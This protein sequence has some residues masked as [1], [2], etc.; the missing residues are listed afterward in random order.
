M[1][2]PSQQNRQTLLIYW[3]HLRR[4]R[5]LLSV[6]F[7]GI[8]LSTIADLIL[9]QFYKELV[10][11][12]TSVPHNQLHILLNVLILIGAIKICSTVFYRIG[13]F[14]Q[15]FF[16]ARVMSDLLNTCFRYLHGH[17][18]GFFNNAFTGSLVRKATRYSRS[19]EDIIDQVLWQIIPSSILLVSVIIILGHKSWLLGFGVLGWALVYIC[20]NVW[21][22]RYKLKF[23]VVR[24][25]SDTAVSGHL[26][27]TL[28]NHLNLKLFSGMQ[29]ETGRFEDLTDNLFTN[30][31]RVW[32]MD[33]ISQGLQ[34]LFMIVLEVGALAIA[35]H[36]WQQGNFSAGDFILLQTY[37]L[38]ISF[39]LWGVGRYLHTIYEELADAREMTEILQT[40]HE[41]RDSSDATDL[42]VTK[43]GIHFDK[44]TFSYT[45]QQTIFQDFNLTIQ[46][47][48]RVALVGSSGSGKST[49]MKLLLRFMD[50]TSGK[51]TLA[52]QEISQI[53]QQSLRDYVA[54]VPQEPSLFH[55]SIIE[56]IRYAKPEASDEEVIAA[57]KS[58][59]C[60]D[61]I[62]QFPEGY[63]TLVGE[64]GVKLSGGERQRIA[65]ARAILKDAPILVLDEATSSLDSHSE[66]LIQ[67]ALKN[68][69]Q[70]KTTIVIAHR[71]STIMQMD[72]IY[73]LS[74]GKIIEHGSH[75][76]LL[77]MKDGA[78]RKLWSIQAGGFIEE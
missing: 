59:H 45:S 64:R 37:I 3:Q 38:A 41:I 15:N 34:S 11:D 24:V 57:A 55:R 6:A 50:I 5:L 31:R 26:A 18:Y 43:G 9:P 19:F 54:L 1:P 46:P 63:D 69:M 67:D 51:I 23:D 40:H 62:R 7:T 76:K 36:L 27:D 35:L 29:S 33:A 49:L 21:F 70:G 20:I 42:V 58:A 17:S 71:L 68:L 10:D 12:L 66:Q 13:H 52:G 14:T 47:G 8:I 30:Q 65:I 77:E 39:H 61:F 73:V 4:Y 74:H 2:T 53:T 28:T 32:D 72:T 56:N 44:M 25:A 16:I 22:V 60:H 48:E 75:E 78:Y